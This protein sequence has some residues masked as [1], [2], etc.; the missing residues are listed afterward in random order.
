MTTQSAS[1]NLRLCV[2]LTINYSNMKKKQLKNQNQSFNGL[3]LLLFMCVSFAFTSSTYAQ[4]IEIKGTVTDAN[5]NPLP[6]TSIITKENQTIGAQTDFD[7]NFSMTVPNTETTLVLSFMG[8][9]TQEIIVGD[10]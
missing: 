10:K 4:S 9:I 3:L 8:F 6:G 1:R 2:N 7:G 5:G